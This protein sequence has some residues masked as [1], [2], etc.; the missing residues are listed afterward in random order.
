MADAEHKK[1]DSPRRPET[2]ISK[3]VPD[4]AN[5][6]QLMRFSGYKADSSE[7]KCVRLYANPELS[8]YWDIPEGDIVHEQAVSA[9]NDPLGSVIL[10][11]KGD[12]QIKSKATK[13][14]QAEGDQM[15]T[16]TPYTPYMAGMQAA[17]QGAGGFTGAIQFTPTLQS[18]FVP[19]VPHSFYWFHCLH[20]LLPPCTIP[21]SP[22]CTITQ[23]F[24]TTIP[25]T[26]PPTTIQTFAG[27][28]FGQ[29]GMAA[30]PQQQAMG[31]GFGPA[32]PPTQLPFQC[33]SPLPFCQPSL[34]P[35]CQPTLPPHCQ[36]TIPPHCHHTLPP[37]CHPS[38]PPLCHPSQPPACHHT[39]VCSLPPQCHPSP[40]PFC[41]HSP[42][43]LC[44]PVS[45][46]PQCVQPNTLPPQCLPPISPFPQCVQPN[47]LPPQCLPPISPF[48]QCV[49]PASPVGGCPT[50][51]TP[52]TP[53]TPNTPATTPVGGGGFGGF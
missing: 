2:F 29:A 48:P 1:P 28:G 40:L 6:S 3:A 53:A 33:V 27:G 45:P 25:T 36:P 23:T 16:Y 44:P 37:L 34:L 11:V 26:I 52:I 20:T 4:P 8:Y 46:L 14:S 43:F 19:C 50:P 47:T 7:P 42:V 32:L 5:P 31:M 21:I 38:Q 9:E 15:H 39:P 10:L 49:P 41:L 17:P 30:A 13:S 51:F 18:I 24:P 35:H 12:S 22:N